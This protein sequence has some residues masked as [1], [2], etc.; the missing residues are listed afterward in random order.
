MNSSIEA[1]FTYGFKVSTVNGS[2]AEV[3]HR[4]TNAQLM[5]SR[6]F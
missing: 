1:S 2:G 6:H 3:S 5:Y 4:Q